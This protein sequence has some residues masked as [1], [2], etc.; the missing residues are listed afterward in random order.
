MLLVELALACPALVAL[1][2]A[3]H[4]AVGGEADWDQI[5]GEQQHQKCADHQGSP[6]RAHDRIAF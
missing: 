5:G 2:F 4:L 3:L 1:A 6:Q